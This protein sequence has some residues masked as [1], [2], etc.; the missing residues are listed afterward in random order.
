MTIA[1]RY[2]LQTGR[3]NNRIKIEYEGKKQEQEQKGNTSLDNYILEKQRINNI[4]QE[5]QE[6]D[7]EKKDAEKAT[8][9]IEKQIAEEIE[10]QVIKRL[11]EALKNL[12]N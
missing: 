5:K 1:E 10:K 3:Q 11:E 9:E 6:Q 4:I 7:K 8:A 12:K 2:A